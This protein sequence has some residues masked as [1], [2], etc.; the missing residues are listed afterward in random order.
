[1]SPLIGE[2]VVGCRSWFVAFIDLLPHLTSF[3]HLTGANT[4]WT[5]VVTA[6]GCFF[7]LR[8]L[9]FISLLLVRLGLFRD[10]AIPGE[11]I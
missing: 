3:P 6:A 5:M 7:V 1:M 2:L 8:I 10:V 4:D 9:S 11:W